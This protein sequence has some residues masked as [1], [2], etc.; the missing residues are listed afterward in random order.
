M[1]DIT[2]GFLVISAI[3]AL[4]CVNCYNKGHESGYKKGLEDSAED[5]D[6]ILDD[7]LLKTDDDDTIGEVD[8]IKPDNN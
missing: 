8:P 1:N 4:A 2:K 7:F 6:E 5:F 3:S